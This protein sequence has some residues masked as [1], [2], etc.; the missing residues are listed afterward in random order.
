M[1]CCCALNCIERR[2][3]FCVA[4]DIGIIIMQRDHRDSRRARNS[5]E[6]VQQGLGERR[7]G[8]WKERNSTE[9]PRHLLQEKHAWTN[10]KSIQRSL[11]VFHGSNSKDIRKRMLRNLSTTL[12]HRN[13]ILKKKK[14]RK[15]KLHRQKTNEKD[16]IHED[17]KAEVQQNLNV[18]NMDASSTVVSSPFPLSP[19]LDVSTAL[20]AKVSQSESSKHRARYQAQP[21]VKSE[22][23]VQKQDTSTRV[24]RLS[25]AQNPVSRAIA[26]TMRNIRKKEERNGEHI[27]HSKPDDRHHSSSTTKV[28][29][30]AARVRRGQ[31]NALEKIRGRQLTVSEMEKFLD[32][33]VIKRARSIVFNPEVDTD[34]TD[35]AQNNSTKPQW[36]THNRRRVLTTAIGK[37]YEELATS[38]LKK[39]T[40]CLHSDPDEV[41]SDTSGCENGGESDDPA[42]CSGSSSESD[43][44]QADPVWKKQHRIR[45][46]KINLA[47]KKAKSRIR[48][49]A[50]KF[51]QKEK[52]IENN[53]LSLSNYEAE[54]RDVVNAQKRARHR[55]RSFL[56]NSGK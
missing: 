38:L 50:R 7:G 53:I 47:I 23:A 49:Y 17:T 41:D 29:I 10:W 51:I 12:K 8:S 43:L 25:E 35:V 16:L 15:G 34:N 54:P 18:T 24:R 3:E 14:C 46:T 48:T 56:L 26:A 37:E 39:H 6:R 45:T 1:I 52:Q 36:Q 20:R 30:E 55:I 32:E 22:E 21:L 4:S 27:Q 9:A 11:S 31:D 2:V 40:V 28:E 44:F 42:N 33:G 19:P 5:H 13:P